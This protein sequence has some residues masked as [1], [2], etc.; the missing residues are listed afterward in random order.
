MIIPRVLPSFK[1]L[2]VKKMNKRKKERIKAIVDALK[3]TVEAAAVVTRDGLLLVISEGDKFS[4]ETVAMGATLLGAAE[5]TTTLIGKGIPS[6][7]I[8]ESERGKLLVIGAGPKV[9]LMILSKPETELE[10]FIKLAEEAART[11]SR[12]MEEIK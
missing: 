10:S 8:V 12:A 7:V 5:T 4:K 11:V 2:E 6:K 9:F 1:N 3:H